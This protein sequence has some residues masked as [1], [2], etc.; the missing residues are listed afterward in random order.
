[1]NS[2]GTGVAKTDDTNGTNDDDKLID[3]AV[4]HGL[5]DTVT[6]VTP[7]D[8]LRT[9]TLERAFSM[10]PVTIRET[11]GWVNLAPGLDYKMLF[12]DREA[13]TKSFLLRAA[14]GARLPAHTHQGTEECLVLEGEFTL[15]ELHLKAGD[16][17]CVDKGT[18][19]AESFT[20][21]GVV[22][23]LKSHILDY[24]DIPA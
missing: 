24:P 13:N 10:S 15:G 18:E 9:R 1:M 5:L 19:H 7:P 20:E 14:A 12:L 2:K 8:S 23:Y 3:D 17:H 16:F 22:V 21:T 4:L 6:P 11:E